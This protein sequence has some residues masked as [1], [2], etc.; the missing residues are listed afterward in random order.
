[1]LYK[2]KTSKDGGR[3]VIILKW[4][5]EDVLLQDVKT[6][7]I[8]TMS[9]QNFFPRHEEMLYACDESKYTGSNLSK[10]LKEIKNDE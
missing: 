5:D 2:Q 8:Y 1:M 9:W 3:A 10:I 6:D 7:L 4:N